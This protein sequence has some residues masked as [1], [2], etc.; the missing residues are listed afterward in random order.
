MEQ[1][2]ERLYQLSET[3][4][5]QIKASF[6]QRRGQSGFAA[7]IDN[8]EVFEAVLFRLRTG[9]P[10]RDLP[11]AYGDWH[12]INTRWQRWV[13][14]GVPQRAMV[15]WHLEAVKR[16]EIDCGLALLDSTIVRAHQHAAGAR[17]KK[18]RRPWAARVA[19]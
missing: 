14:S 16:G 2:Q 4:W 8:R 3:Q 12:A 13:K 6:P 18:A 17:K 7:K 15:A 9:C 10:W 5:E 19:A 11:A 1:T